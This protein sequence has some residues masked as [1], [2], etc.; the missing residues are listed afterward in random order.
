MPSAALTFFCDSCGQPLLLE[1]EASP[2]LRVSCPSC[3]AIVEVPL[4][5]GDEPLE[6]SWFAMVRGSQVGPMAQGPLEQLI[7]AGEV[8]PKS[9]VWCEGMAEWRRA[10]TLPQLAQVP[11]RD[12][13]PESG[14]HRR[15]LAA[16]QRPRPDR[17]QADG[18]PGR[19]ADALRE[20]GAQDRPARARPGHPDGQHSRRHPDARVAVDDDDLEASGLARRNPLW[21][22]AL[23]V[24]LVVAV[25]VAGLYALSSMKVIPLEVP[26]VDPATGASVNEPVFS[27]RGVRGLKDLLLGN[28]AAARA[29]GASAGGPRAAT[30]ACAPPGARGVRAEARAARLARAQEALRRR[31]EG[32]RRPHRDSRARARRPRLRRPVPD[33]TPRPWRRWWRRAGRRSRAASSSS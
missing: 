31:P 30:E 11:R 4:P 14:Q 2:G 8:T 6:L 27:A 22:V 26:R 23:A 18:R 12:P 13:T 7:R 29:P 1:G 33:R 32:R 3:Q 5:A 10:E 24:L 15:P 19:G 25:P 28:D 20:P 9:F 16:L 17:L 21:K